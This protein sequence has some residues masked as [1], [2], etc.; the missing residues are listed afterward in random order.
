MKARSQRRSRTSVRP[1]IKY[2]FTSPFFIL[3][4]VDDCN[5]V[6]VKFLLAAPIIY[7]S[8]SQPFSSRDPILYR[9]SD[10]RPDTLKKKFKSPSNKTRI[11]TIKINSS[12]YSQNPALEKLRKSYKFYIDLSKFPYLSVR[13]SLKR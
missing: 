5:I 11:Y 10:R 3:L 6:I 1:Y 2:L 9:Q 13:P 8:G 4:F 12:I 7:I